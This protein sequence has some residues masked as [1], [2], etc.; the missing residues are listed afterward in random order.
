MDISCQSRTDCNWEKPRHFGTIEWCGGKDEI[1]GRGRVG[2]SRGS[3]GGSCHLGPCTP[4]EVAVLSPDSWFF[5]VCNV[6]AWLKLF[7]AP[8]SNRSILNKHTLPA[9]G[10]GKG[11]GHPTP[12]PLSLLCFTDLGWFP[13]MTIWAT[14]NSHSCVV[15]L[16][17]QNNPLKAQSPPSTLIKA[18]PQAGRLSF[19]LPVTSLCGLSCAVYLPGPVTNK[20]GSSQ[21]L[22]VAVK[23][24]WAGPTTQWLLRVWEQQNNNYLDFVIR[25]TINHT[26]ECDHILERLTTVWE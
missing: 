23:P 6:S 15:N 10:W 11:P 22:P 16:P 14:L 12:P 20:P 9:V 2:R 18:E 5:R 3:C 24:T 8:T 13:W 7:E 17:V 25:S 26:E 21:S 19:T 4:T 1:R